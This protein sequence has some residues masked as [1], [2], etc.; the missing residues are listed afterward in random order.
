MNHKRANLIFPL[1][2]IAL[3]LLIW[4]GFSLLP[5]SGLPSPWKTWEASRLYLLRPWEKRGEMDQGILRFLSYS[6]LLV[7]KGYTIAILA[8]VPLGLALGLW[9][10]FSLCFDPL[11]QILRPVSPLAWLPLGLI[12]FRRSEPAAIFTIAIC[13]MWPTVLNTATGVKNI[14]QEYWNVARSLNLSSWKTLWKIVIPASL[15][16][17]F[18]G[19]RL[20]LGIA[21]LVIVAAEM[22]TGSPGIGGFLWQEYNS[23]VYEHILLCILTIGLV[24]FAL[25]RMMALLEERL[26]Y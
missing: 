7:A 2:G 5:G 20:S 11:V 3:L 4:A 26:R 10:P 9:R 18:T 19:F 15:P 22:L 24:G 1:L 8:G 21:W 6:L 23:L 14:P 25:D 13:A 17:M 12:L 16:Y